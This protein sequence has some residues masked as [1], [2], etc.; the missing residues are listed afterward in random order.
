ML[1]IDVVHFGCANA[2]QQLIPEFFLDCNVLSHD[3]D[4]LC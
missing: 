3:K 1:S 4:E 2:G